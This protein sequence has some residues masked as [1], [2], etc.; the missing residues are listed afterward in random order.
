MSELSEQQAHN[1]DLTRRAFEAFDSENAEPILALADE[2]IEIHMPSDLPNS[3]TYRGHDGYLEW[4][5]NWL[6]AWDGFSV[7]VRGMKPVGA[8]HI[9]TS[10]KQ[11]ATGKGS[12]VPVHMEMAYLTEV[13][14]D[15]FIALHLYLTPEQAVEVAERREQS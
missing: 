4:L 7:E 2:A 5:G 15:K 14:G 10:A 6:E 3:G 1:L 11:T 8:R 13:R 12:G 9:V